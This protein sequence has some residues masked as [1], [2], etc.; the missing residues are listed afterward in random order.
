V[1]AGRRVEGNEK[2]RGEGY[3]EGMRNRRG[4]EEEMEG[5]LL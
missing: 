2:G 5:H 1:Y 3:E 4:G